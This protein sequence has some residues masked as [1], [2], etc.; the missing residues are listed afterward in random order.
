MRKMKNKNLK[1][2]SNCWGGGYYGDIMHC[3]RLFISLAGVCSYFHPHG[4]NSTPTSDIKR[5]D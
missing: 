1:F 5:G 4:S 3:F 2:S